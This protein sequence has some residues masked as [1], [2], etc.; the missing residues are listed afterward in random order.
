[1]LLTCELAKLTRPKAMSIVG[2]R[3]RSPKSLDWFS[4]SRCNEQLQVRILV[5]TPV[6]SMPSPSSNCRTP[7]I[8]RST[9]EFWEKQIQL[10]QVLES[11][12]Y[13]IVT[14]IIQTHH[15]NMISII[16]IIITIRMHL[17]VGNNAVH[18]VFGT[19]LFIWTT[20][21]IFYCTISLSPQNI[22]TLKFGFYQKCKREV[23]EEE[24]GTQMTYNKELQP[25]LF[26]LAHRNQL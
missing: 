17:V 2:G 7:A 21:M 3:M 5:T 25:C 8:C 15:R 4:I 10:K 26:S 6:L 19:W 12:L 20:Q 16:A 11:Q 24:R 23:E 13:P 18:L 9:F 22:K 1:M 14:M